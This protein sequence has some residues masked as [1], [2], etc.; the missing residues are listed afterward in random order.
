MAG[1]FND[2]GNAIIYVDG[3]NEG[4]QPL[5]GATLS[6]GSQSV[7]IGVNTIGVMDAI[8][9]YNYALTASQVF[10]FARIL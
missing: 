5:N 2:G 3:Q 1:V 4:S 7:N 9:I 6:E 10:T 8:Q